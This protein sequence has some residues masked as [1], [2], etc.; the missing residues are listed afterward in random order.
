VRESDLERH[1]T[2]SDAN[3][4]ESESTEDD[5]AEEPEEEENDPQLTRALEVLK[6]WNYFDGLRASRPATP[7][8]AK[9]P[10]SAL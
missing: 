6:S 8:Q 5:E 3:S 1:F 10:E 2:Q 7:L 4:D 9:A